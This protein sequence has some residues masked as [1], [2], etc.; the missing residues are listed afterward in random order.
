MSD[1]NGK[2][3]TRSFTDRRIAGVCGG[4][5][6]YLNVDPTLIRIIFL[7]LLC[8]VGGGLV[9]YLLMWLAMPEA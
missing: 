6:S 1:Y 8:C 2:R 7:V 5:G 4:L 3:L 9:L